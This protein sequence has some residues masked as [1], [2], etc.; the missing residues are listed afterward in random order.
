MIGQW[1][2]E[3]LMSFEEWLKTGTVALYT[4]RF[5]SELFAVVEPDDEAVSPVE[6]KRTPVYKVPVERSVD[7][8]DDHEDDDDYDDNVAEFRR[9]T[10]V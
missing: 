1:A 4:W 10:T 8:D 3:L 6:Q 7:E 2:Y 9:T 5:D